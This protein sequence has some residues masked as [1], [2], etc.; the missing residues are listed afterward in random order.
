MVPFLRGLP[1]GR[2]VDR[3]QG[4]P[5]TRRG[6][7]RKSKWMRRCARKDEWRLVATGSR[8]GV[9]PRAAKPAAGTYLVIFYAVVSDEIQQVIEFFSTPAEAQEI[10]ERVLNDEPDWREILHIERWRLSP[11]VRTKGSPRGKE[12]LTRPPDTD[13]SCCRRRS[14]SAS[15]RCG[16]AGTKECASATSS[17]SPCR[18]S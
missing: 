17:E 4:D 6:V 1:A 5:A 8:V 2:S 14:P 10:L 13:R 12:A 16:I 7:A 15:R 18:N 9:C 11:A 3:T